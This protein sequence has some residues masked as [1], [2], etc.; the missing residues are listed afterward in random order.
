MTDEA[1]RQNICAVL[2]L[3]TSS[4]CVCRKDER[5]ETEREGSIKEQRNSRIS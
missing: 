1:D 5:N 2:L 4:V 3:Y